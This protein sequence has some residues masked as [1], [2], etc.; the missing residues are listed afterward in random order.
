MMILRKTMALLVAT[1]ITFMAADAPGE[2]PRPVS[3]LPQP[4]LQLRLGGAMG[5]RIDH[6][7]QEWILTA[8]AAN[9][10]MLEMFRMRDRQP[11]YENPVP[12]AGEFAG[13]Y[14]TSA[15]LLR[16]MSDDPRLDAQIRD[17]VAELISTQADD[18]YMGP[19][20]RD[21]RLLG[22][23]DLW[24]HYH[25]MLGL[26]LWYRDTGDTSA[27]DAAVRA[28]DLVCDTYLDTGKRV[29]DAGSHEMNMAIIHIL[30]ILERQTGNERYLRM[31]KEIMTDWEKAPA[32]DYYRQGVAGV[33]F[34][35][36]PKPR[37]ESLHPM[38]GLGEMYRIT[39]Y[40]SYRDALLH[41]WHSIRRT[42]IHNAGSFSTNEGAV[43]NPF[44]GGSIE[45]CCTVAWLAYSADALRL[46]AESVVADAMELATWNTVLGYQHPSGRWCT[47]STP[48]DGKREA[49]AHTIVFQS[50]A[51]T[52]EL[53]CCSVNGPRGL[54]M[55]AEWAVL[56]D[57][58]G[59]YLNYYGPGEIAAT[60]DDG[61]AWRFV[62]DTAYPVDGAVRIAVTPP[63]ESA[64]PLYLRI[65]EW[66]AA[67]TVA[68]NGEAIAGVA[69]GTYAKLERT[70]RADDVIEL[71]LDMALRALRGDDHVDFN[72]SLYHGPLLLAYDQKF[73][74]AE[75]ADLPRLDLA[76]LDLRPA[77]AAA[78]YQPMVLFAATAEDG[79]TLH[80]CDYAT[81][82]AHGTYY[83]SW[84]PVD[85]APP[86]AFF[87]QR[88]AQDSVLAAGDVLLRWSGAGPDMA[89][90]V[91]V[92]SDPAFKNVVSEFSD[93][94]ETHVVVQGVARQDTPL[95][96]DV[97]VTAS[98]QATTSGNG[99][100]SFTP[101][102]TAPAGERGTLV[103]LAGGSAEPAVGQLDH[104]TDV[105][106]A[107][108]PDGAGGLLFNGSTSRAV[109]AVPNFPVLNYSAAAWIRPEALRGDDPA[110]HEIFSAWCRA[111]DDPLRLVVSGDQVFARIEQQGGF[112]S[113][114]GR[115]IPAQEWTH[116]ALVKEG[117]DLRLYVNGILEHLARVPDTVETLST[118]IG[119]GCNPKFTDAEAFHGAVA[120]AI[121]VERAWSDAE[122]LALAAK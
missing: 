14:L 43:G 56:G 113:T 63:K 118:A 119:I 18:G 57:G 69:A 82:G 8:P 116:V 84:L 108:G 22:N 102:R 27:L 66:S 94:R 39:G 34:Y 107:E 3:E 9:P 71:Q 110:L 67:T 92:A 1:S 117:V 74:T 85:H 7:I 58:D 53:N 93:V 15:V 98:Q 114:A 38:L 28:A 54:G 47:Y 100:W 70:W 61:S 65:P 50:R 76:T 91:R 68:V 17:F 33:E 59:L 12:W 5:A 104:A 81:A 11:P 30:G 24:G 55:I 62:Q 89:Y 86:V 101:S 99:P 19:F 2:E 46:S 49:S 88:P 80:L 31:M 111:S 40:E 29:Y 25:V 97:A 6:V 45:T 42:D 120:P 10:G 75:P 13:K 96:W 21:Q 48:M 79:S 60:L 16:R 121:V 52:P 20:P 64:T 4:T 87:L 35:Q 103:K 78:R 105:E 122:V 112:Y 115:R 23:W 106:P 73:N 37:W 95:Y 83:R 36:T 51:G 90:A 26:Y 72:T 109:Y 32:G 41:F 77:A 44:V